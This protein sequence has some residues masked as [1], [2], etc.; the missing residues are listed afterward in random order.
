MWPIKRAGTTLGGQGAGDYNNIMAKYTAF[1]YFYKCSVTSQI[2]KLPTIRRGFI[3]IPG[4][5]QFT[6]RQMAEADVLI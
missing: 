1:R 2:T 6:F 3:P 5:R 4:A